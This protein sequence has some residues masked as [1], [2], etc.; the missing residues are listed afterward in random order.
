MDDLKTDNYLH[1]H[2][3][4]FKSIWWD[5]GL[6]I[7]ILNLNLSYTCVYSKTLEMAPKLEK[8]YNI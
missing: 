8:S 1:L 2:T 6:Y 4:R 3:T 5:V 7:F